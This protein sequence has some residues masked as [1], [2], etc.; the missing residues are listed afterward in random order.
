VKVR[1]SA[2]TGRTIVL[3]RPSLG[4]LGARLIAS[5]AKVEHIPLIAIGPPADGGRALRSALGELGDFDWLVVTSANGAAAVADA[6][7][8]VPQVRLAAVGPATAAA[9]Q[10]RS[11]RRVDV[12]PPN[13]NNE[14][15]LAAFPSGPSRVLLA[16]AD[17]AGDRLAV[18]LRAAGHDVVAVEAYATRP[19]PPGTAQL[20]V[21]GSADAVVL[22]SG[23]AVAAWSS[24]VGDV[25]GHG[26]ADVT[27]AI[28]TIGQRTAAVAESH[29]LV[30][31]AVAGTPDDESILAA[32]VE[33][34]AVR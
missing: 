3:T 10:A 24:S 26:F 21:L 33:V 14:G 15:L 32:V 19:Q 4:T 18:G 29:G 30:V 5:G 6:L 31:A 22:A 7:A 34:L 1:A 16:Q 17:R 2:L 25:A 27:A 13:A 9:L 28:V 8:D 23:S 20:E 12:V 11:G